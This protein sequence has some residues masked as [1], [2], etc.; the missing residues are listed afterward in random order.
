MSDRRRGHKAVK[1][2]IT[3]LGKNP[4]A[5]EDEF[6]AKQDQLERIVKPLTGPQR[7]GT[8]EPRTREVAIQEQTQARLEEPVQLAEQARLQE[9]EQL[10]KQAKLKELAEEARLA[11]DDVKALEERLKTCKQDLKEKG[12]NLETA[13]GNL[14]AAEAAHQPSP[15]DKG[16][17][18]SWR[19]R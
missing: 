5:A 11:E 19:Q 3:W 9:E 17:R 4:N 16:P 8:K 15:A 10:A 13:V 12:K 14:K 7:L 2:V 1:N 6:K 18:S